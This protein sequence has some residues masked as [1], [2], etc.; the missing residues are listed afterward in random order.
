MGKKIEETTDKSETTDASKAFERA[1]NGYW[2]SLH[3]AHAN[4]CASIEK[5]QRDWGREAAKSQL[6]AQKS[7]SDA[8]FGYWEA[9]GTAADSENAEKLSEDA[10]SAYHRES[11]AAAETYWKDWVKTTHDFQRALAEAQEGYAQAHEAAGQDYL[12]AIKEAWSQVEA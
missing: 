6:K 1:S 3:E 5:I 7:C 8:Y 4:A 9:V 12:R 2:Q 11:Q 10:A